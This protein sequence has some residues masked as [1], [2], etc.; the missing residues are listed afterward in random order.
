MNTWANNNVSQR[1]TSCGQLG[2]V[3]ANLPSRLKNTFEKIS[4][5]SEP[6]RTMKAQLASA[7]SACVLACCLVSRAQDAPAAVPTAPPPSQP[8]E[9]PAASPTAAAE[10]APTTPPPATPP[11]GESVTPAA[12]P[13]DA[14]AVPSDAAAAPAPGAVIPYIQF[15]EIPLTSA[16][17]NLA[18]QA[19]LNY[20][21]DPKVPYGQP[22]PDG[23]VTPQPNISI[24]WENLTAE[25]ALSA[26]LT[27]YNL[28]LVDDPKT[29]VSRITVKDPAAP[30]PIITRIVQLKHAGVTNLLG[31]VQTTF[32]DKRSK[33]VGDVRTS[34]LVIVA[35]E[36]EQEEALALIERLDTPTRQVLIE[37]RLMEI[38]RS[39]STVKGIDWTDTLAAQRFEFGNNTPDQQSG[40]PDIPAIPSPDG[41]ITPG[42][43][44]VRGTPTIFGRNFAGAPRLAVNTAN[45]FY[46]PIG[47]LNADG[48]SAVLSFLNADADTQVI[49]TP[50]AVTL[51]NE[52]ATLSVTRA[53]P[54]FK[55]TAGTQGSPGGSEVQYT[56]L[57][58][59]LNVTPRISANDNIWLRVVPEVSSIFR[60]VTKTVA[61][62]INQA[63][64]YDIRKVETQVLIPSATTLVMGGLMADS[65]KNIYSKIPL[66]GDIP[67]IG[68][69]FRHEN[70]ARDKRNLL[71]FITPTIVKDTD[72]QPAPNSSQF[73]KT[74]QTEIT[75]A[76]DTSKAWDSA[77]P[78]DWSN[79]DATP[80][81]EA[82][83]N[84][85]AV[86]PKAKK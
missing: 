62:S 35:T 9:T 82:T 18:R 80:Y 21:L 45:G 25:Q 40:T 24:R 55:N 10:A 43:P 7:I 65:T 33:V 29:K 60:T 27:V 19:G 69:A 81:E 4:S 20:I 30:D 37:A 34:Q 75:S 70:K 57:G 66:L 44:G 73:L 2:T 67:G 36:K 46:P 3:A 47:F 5:M 77:K 15:Q 11:P 72:F 13:A 53:V 61:G 71:I 23:K 14:I 74:R 42:T 78:Y 22:G 76:I 59:I 6:K 17:E 16:I 49:S 41:G 51:D 86:E 58:T 48:V 28:Q 50:R 85:K 52:T 31:P 12:V 63:D 83:F 64:E 54:I 39:P 79:P 1:I 56:N 8:A 84:E 68:L 26:L 38:S 32:I